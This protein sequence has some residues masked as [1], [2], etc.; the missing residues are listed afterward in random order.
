MKSIKKKLFSFF[1]FFLIKSETSD[2]FLNHF[3]GHFAY[4]KPWTFTLTFERTM[5]TGALAAATRRQSDAEITDMFKNQN[6][7]TL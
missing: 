5:Y 4:L 1:I 3:D 6:Q 2:S 7:G